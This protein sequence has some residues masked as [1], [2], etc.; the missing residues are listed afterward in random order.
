MT[1][2]D[3]NV[4]VRYL[5]GD[6]PDQSARAQALIDGRAVLVPVTVVPE[7]GWVLQSAYGFPA[8]D[9]IRALRSFGGLATVTVEDGDGRHRA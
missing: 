5:T 8:S 3:A 7:T 1:A 2:I 4:V 6:D 9:T